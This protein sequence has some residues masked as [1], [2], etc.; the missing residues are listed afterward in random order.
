M[1]WFYET[2]LKDKDVV[3]QVEPAV[4]FRAIAIVAPVAAAYYPEQVQNINAKMAI[5]RM[6][7]D[8]INRFPFHADYIHQSLGQKEHFYKVYKDVHHFAF[9]SP[10]PE[11]LL[12]EEYIP[13]AI[14][15]EGF[16]R[17]KFLEEINTDIL[18]FFQKEMPTK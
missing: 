10:Y 11:W 18:N 6:E 17:K 14:D 13:V 2:G 5:F 12:K 9:I 4:N 3:T 7:S 16:N 1:H 15:P 8:Q